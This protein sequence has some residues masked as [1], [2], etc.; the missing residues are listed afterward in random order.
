MSGF[1][2]TS[3]FKFQNVTLVRDSDLSVLLNF[4]TGFVPRGYHDS[5]GT[6]LLLT[7]VHHQFCLMKKENKHNKKIREPYEPGQTPKPPQ[8]IEPN[9][10]RERENPVENKNRPD[11]R[12]EKKPQA[13]ESKPHLLS[14][15]ADIDD[16][17][18]I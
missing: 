14:D 4:Y 3:G 5:S 2:Q 11:A 13:T 15:E 9:T 17:T 18:T 10:E 6:V 16:E 7:M 1:K 12:D 8:I